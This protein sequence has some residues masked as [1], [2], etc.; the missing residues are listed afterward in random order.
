MTTTS[1]VRLPLFPKG[2]QAD[3]EIAAVE[4]LRE[5]FELGANAFVKPAQNAL[6][7]PVRMT[8]R[9]PGSATTSRS[10]PSSDRI[11]EADAAFRLSGRL[12]VKVAMTSTVRG[13]A[14][15]SCT[16]VSRKDFSASTSITASGA[17]TTNSAGTSPAY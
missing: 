15:A 6:P 7:V 10:Q 14:G 4:M 16:F 17:G 2:C 8:Q 1:V 13:R 12:K 11:S 3:L 9:R 5:V